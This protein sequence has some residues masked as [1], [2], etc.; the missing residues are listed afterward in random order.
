MQAEDFNFLVSELILQRVR[1]AP[2][3]AVVGA[4]RVSVSDD[5]DAGHVSTV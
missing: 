1:S 3:H 4:Q 5:E 2:S